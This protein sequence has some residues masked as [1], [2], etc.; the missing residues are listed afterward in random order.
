M[1]T[2]SIACAAAIL[3]A[4]ALLADLAS[5]PPPTLMTK[6]GKLL[7]AEN[8]SKPLPPPQGSTANYASGFKGWRCNVSERG[9]RWDIVDGAFRGI[10]NPKVNHPAC[11]S[12][13]LDFKNVIIACEA[14][15]HD[16]PLEGRKF[17]GFSVRTTD[18]K[19]Y[20]CSVMLSQAGMRIQKDDN[21]HAGP[22]KAVP[23][24]EIKTPIKLG[25][26]Q[27]IVFEILDDEMVGTLNGK[28][29]T[30]QHPLIASDK[31]SIMFVSS[32]EGSVRNLRVWEALPN[33]DW[34]KNKR[35][36]LAASKGS[37]KK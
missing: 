12:I 18:A 32:V 31:H 22:D 7:V 27:T 23:F 37:A 14:R 35:T 6:A 30:G 19:D 29:L 11:A 33:P 3:P 2:L 34:T 24:G 5:M 9:G 36:I 26:W 13:G 1:K 21:D 20:V 28:S 10:E 17:R 16:V 8:F 15:M 25:E 4:H